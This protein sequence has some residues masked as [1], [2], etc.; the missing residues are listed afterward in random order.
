MENPPRIRGG[1]RQSHLGR[2]GRVE[3]PEKHW[4]IGRSGSTKRILEGEEV[5]EGGNPK[6][7]GGASVGY[8]HQSEVAVGGGGETG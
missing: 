3:E 6:N 1:R 2:K 8:G 5:G 4:I 7:P